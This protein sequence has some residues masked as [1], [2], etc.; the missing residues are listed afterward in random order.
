MPSVLKTS[1]LC[2]HGFKALLKQVEMR[3]PSMNADKL[4]RHCRQG[5]VKVELHCQLAV[6]PVCYLSMSTPCLCLARMSIV[7]SSLQPKGSLAQWSCIPA[8][9]T[10][11]VGTKLSLHFFLPNSSLFQLEGTTPIRRQHIPHRLFP[12][13]RNHAPS[14]HAPQIHPRHLQPLRRRRSPRATRRP[15]AR[16]HVSQGPRRYIQGPPQTSVA[17]CCGV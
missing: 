5:R 7:L 11:Y 14:L 4:H 15:L 1:W 2:E 3:D 6:M 17:S 12:L 8:T 13:Q 9:R 16:R 10:S